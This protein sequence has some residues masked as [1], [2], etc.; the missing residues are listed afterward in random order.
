MAN[1]T[2]LESYSNELAT[3]VRTL[4]GYTSTRESLLDP[5]AHKEAHRAKGRIL[6][7]VAAIKTLIYGPTD[8][9]E[10][11]AIQ[12]HALTSVEWHSPFRS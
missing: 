2:Q 11:L 12:V 6:S 1:L 8:F 3:A 10:H 4:T 7:C 9:L 5:N